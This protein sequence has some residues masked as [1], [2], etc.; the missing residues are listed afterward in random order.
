MMAA[1]HMTRPKTAPA[2]PLPPPRHGTRTHIAWEGGWV[3]RMGRGPCPRLSDNAPRT[4][5][6]RGSQ[7]DTH[8][9]SLIAHNCTRDCDPIFRD[10]CILAISAFSL[11]EKDLRFSRGFLLGRLL[12]G[13]SPPP[14]HLLPLHPRS[15]LWARPP[16]CNRRLTCVT[17]PAAVGA[18]CDNR[19]S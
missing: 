1:A 6:L 5:T 11:P 9:D 7:G 2:P 13:L 15:G 3:T 4:A 8:A 19:L 14:F 10:T 18:A 17:F 16:L 12:C